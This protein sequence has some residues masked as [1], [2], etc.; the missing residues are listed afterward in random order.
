VLTGVWI[1]VGFIHT[2]KVVIFLGFLTL[3]PDYSTLSFLAD[4]SAK[5]KTA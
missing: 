5:Q 2:L 4:L 3:L 1:A